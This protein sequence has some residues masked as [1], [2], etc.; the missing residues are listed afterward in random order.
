[1]NTTPYKTYLSENE[2]PDSW[3]NLRADMQKK[4]VTAEELEQVF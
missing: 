1:M 4:P 2:L 3:Y